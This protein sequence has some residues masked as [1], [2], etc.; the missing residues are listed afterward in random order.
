MLAFFAFINP[1]AKLIETHNYVLYT[2]HYLV[3]IKVFG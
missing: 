1:L 2:F 3:W